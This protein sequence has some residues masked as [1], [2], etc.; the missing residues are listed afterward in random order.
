MKSLFITPTKIDYPP[1]DGASIAAFY[2]AYYLKKKFDA[3]CDLIAPGDT[4]SKVR[5]EK[6]GVFR[7]LFLYNK[8]PLWY[9]NTKALLSIYTFSMIRN[10]LNHEDIDNIGNM[11]DF[12]E[13][14]CINFEHSYSYYVY[15]QLS[16]YFKSTHAKKVFWAHNVD[17]VYFYNLFK[18]SKQ[19][20]EK[21]INFLNYIKLRFLEP[22]YLKKFDYILTLAYH[23]RVNLKKILNQDNIYWIPVN[24]PE[25]E[26]KDKLGSVLDE[27]RAKTHNC[28]YRIIF[29][30]KLN[31]ISNIEAVLWF[32]NRVLPIIRENLKDVCFLI[33]GYAPDKSIRSLENNKDIFLYSNVDSVSPFFYLAD[34][35]VIPLFNNAGIKIK[36][37]EAIKHKTKIVARPEALVG[38]NLTN[39]IPNATNE[40]EFAN[41]C[42]KALKNE[43]NFDDILERANEM[44]DD[45]KNLSLYLNLCQS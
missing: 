16:K 4:D 39:I 2:R 36:L 31:H 12:D 35:C 14:D 20:V 5:L 40:K 17:Y 42:L 11:F 30:G 9:S 43:I 44:F 23:D 33:V 15:N 10:S 26:Q 45:H 7:K 41:L 1:K 13:Y 38:A 24:V 27:L 6:T 18:E 3:T 37:I 28:K 34:L 8:K 19:T 32:S 25:P 22:R 21:F 29:T